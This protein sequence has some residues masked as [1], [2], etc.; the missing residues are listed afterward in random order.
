MLVSSAFK[1][2]CSRKV[3]GDVLGPFFRDARVA[4]CQHHYGVTTVQV[5]VELGVH[6]GS[7]AVVSDDPLAVD[8][9]F[10]LRK[11]A[12]CY[13]PFRSR[14]ACDRAHDLDIFDFSPYP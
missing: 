11:V 2:L 1:S 7:A 13:F 9:F 3:V 12:V 5:H 4:I 6:T 8:G 14:A 10:G